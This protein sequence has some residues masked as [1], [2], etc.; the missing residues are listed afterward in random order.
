MSE[1]AEI[2]SVTEKEGQKERTSEKQKEIMINELKRET[3]TIQ[4][5]A[6]KNKKKKGKQMKKSK[7]KKES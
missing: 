5:R 4:M 1:L 2:F 3:K 7:K 6:K